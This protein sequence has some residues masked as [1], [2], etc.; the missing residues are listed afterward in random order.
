MNLSGIHYVGATLNLKSMTK[1]LHY[2]LH[3]AYMQSLSLPKDR[4]EKHR[5]LH[6]RIRTIVVGTDVVKCISLISF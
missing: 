5:N 3:G 4:T 6:S 2:E 1:E